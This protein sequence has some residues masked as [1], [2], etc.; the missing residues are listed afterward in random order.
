MTERAN[1]RE[2]ID[3]LECDKAGLPNP[4]HVAS[5]ESESAAATEKQIKHLKKK[6]QHKLK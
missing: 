1:M 5:K 2:M 3:Q 4:A 6:S